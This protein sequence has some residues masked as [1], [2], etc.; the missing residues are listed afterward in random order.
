MLRLGGILHGNGRIE[1]SLYNNGIVSASGKTPLEVSTDYY[2][3]MD[4]RL[5]VSIADDTSTGLK[6]RGKAILAGT[7]DITRS[8]LSAKANTPYT[9]LTAS[10]IEGT[11][12]NMNQRVTDGNDQLFSIHYTHS[13]VSLVPVK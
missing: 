6:V 12:R 13:E 3:T 1:A 7:L 8:N 5:R 2:E 9:I 4:A 11:F 10:Q